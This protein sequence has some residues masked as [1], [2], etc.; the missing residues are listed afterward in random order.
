ML[1]EVV[2]SNTMNNKILY[3]VKE[4]A[5][6]IHTNPTYVYQLIN[7]GLLPALKLGSYKVRHETLIDFLQKY[8]GMD[9]T[10]PH[11][12]VSL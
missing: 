1:W 6:I 12:I 8:E 3:T 9:L 10:D 4:V 11:N 7:T 5:E 2:G